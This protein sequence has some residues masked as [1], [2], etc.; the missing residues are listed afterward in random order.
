MKISKKV[1]LSGLIIG[2][3]FIQNPI[4]AQSA[5]MYSVRAQKTNFNQNLNDYSDAKSIQVSNLFIKEIF[6]KNSETDLFLGIR[7]EKNTSLLG[8]G[9]VFDVDHDQFYADDI[10]ILNTNNHK[11]DGYFYQG[12]A[13]SIQ[14]SNYFSG[15]VSTITYVDGLSYDLFQFTIPFNPNS[16]PTTD[17][18]I[19]DPSDYMLGIDTIEIRNGSLIS[20]TR[21]N[22]GFESIQQLNSNSDSFFNLI[23]AGPGKFAVPDFNPVVT[24]ISTN[25]VSVTQSTYYNESDSYAAASPG[26]ELSITMLFL[27]LIPIFRKIR[28]GR[29]KS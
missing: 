27:I 13:L 22:L 8:I 7:V 1:V 29:S 11:S 6:L 2:L 21:G 17:M 3:V 12:S 28:S 18:I 9:I 4:I 20:W 5:F 25:T 14:E 23:L 15:F 19:A 26:F 16:N 24:T 10:K